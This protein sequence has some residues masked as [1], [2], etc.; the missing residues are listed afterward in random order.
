M[1]K[2]SGPATLAPGFGLRFM[3]RTRLT[4]RR[5]IAGSAS[6]AAT[7]VVAP[8]VRGNL[9]QSDAEFHSR[10]DACPDRVWLGP[11]YW[12]NP[13]QDWRI[14][15]G[16][17]EC[18]NAAPDRNVHVLTRQLGERKGDARHERAGRPGRERTAGHAQA[19][20][21]FASVRRVRCASTATA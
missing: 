1:Q 20:S 11:E 5:F 8:L 6:L 21:V 15:G 14:A 17:I 10:W 16:R 18:T 7:S 2:A 13:L 12:A 9:L 19:R 3:S 4:R